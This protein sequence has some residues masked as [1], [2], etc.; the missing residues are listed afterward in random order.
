MTKYT[1]YALFRAV[2][3]RIPVGQTEEETLSM[4][5]DFGDTVSIAA[6]NSS[7]SLTLSGGK[8]ALEEIPRI[9]EEF[10]QD[11]N[12]LG[13]ASNL[14]QPLETAGRVADFQPVPGPEA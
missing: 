14:N 5:G 13:S 9:R 10:W 4:L 2:H 3:G 8:K 11:V 12:V 7:T 6:I 1:L